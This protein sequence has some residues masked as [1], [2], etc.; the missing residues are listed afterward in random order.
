MSESAKNQPVTSC[1]CGQ[2]RHLAHLFPEVQGEMLMLALH[3]PFRGRH[4]GKGPAAVSNHSEVVTQWKTD[5]VSGLRCWMR[6][7]LFCQKRETIFCKSSCWIQDSFP[8]FQ[9]RNL[10]NA[11]HYRAYT[12][13]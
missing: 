8:S 6:I 7:C 3:F 2:P 4:S 12:V 13:G 11:C 9:K 10:Q 1:M 5:C